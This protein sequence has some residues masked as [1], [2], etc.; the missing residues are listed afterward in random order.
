[1]PVREKLGFCQQ[2][3][4]K[5]IPQVALTRSATEDEIVWELSTGIMSMMDGGAQP[6]MRGDRVRLLM[7]EFKPWLGDAILG[8]IYLPG[9]Y[10][11]TDTMAYM[12]KLIE[13]ACSKYEIGQAEFRKMLIASNP[14]TSWT[15]A[16]IRLANLC[17]RH[18][19]QVF[20]HEGEII[21]LKDENNRFSMTPIQDSGVMLVS[22]VDERAK[23]VLFPYGIEDVVAYMTVC[24][25]IIDFQQRGREE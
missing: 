1:M 17:Y 5:G 22:Q 6:T 8:R 12:N 10:G 20:C 7:I 2:M 11:P 15:L 3:V 19:Y 9:S 24:N 16:K 21:W 25:A 18:L 23:E 13:A 14:A 4:A